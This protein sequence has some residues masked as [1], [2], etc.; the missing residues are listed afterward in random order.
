MRKVIADDLDLNDE[1]QEATRGPF[2][3]VCTAE[4]I[5]VDDVPQSCVVYKLHAGTSYEFY[6]KV[7]NVLV[8]TVLRSLL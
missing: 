3:A 1:E 7:H 8:S 2:Q 5:Q 4:S 6:S